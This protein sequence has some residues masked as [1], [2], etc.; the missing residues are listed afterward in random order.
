MSS[1]LFRVF[2]FTI[3]LIQ[4]CNPLPLFAAPQ[5]QE[6]G[7]Y[8]VGGADPSVP[9]LPLNELEPEITF[10]IGYTMLSGDGI[11]ELYTGIPQFGIG[12]SFRTARDIRS[13]FRLDYG[14]T[15][16]DPLEHVLGFDAPEETTVRN[17]PFSFGLLFNIS[18][19]EK[20]RLLI[21]IGAQIAWQQEE[22]LANKPG[23]NFGLA[24][25][26]GF[27]FGPMGSFG[28]EILLGEKDNIAG[29]EFAYG[30][31]RGRIHGNGS[32]HDIDLS[33]V[34]IRAYYGFKL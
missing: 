26:S 24:N 1:A 30:G 12:V 3:V 9:P 34:T 13:F 25:R 17:I 31:V 11:D 22:I 33:G 20:L 18:G 2:I 23:G 21:G 32:T 28:T 16:G 27:N 14:A 19:N 29:L 7:S 10:G 6:D 8:E 5:G 15:S 4:F